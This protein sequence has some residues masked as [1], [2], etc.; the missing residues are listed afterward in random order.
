M[1][2]HEK[3]ED[4]DGYDIEKYSQAQNYFQESQHQFNNAMEH[5]ENCITKINSFHL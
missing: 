4:I 3:F 5:L 2:A 1:E